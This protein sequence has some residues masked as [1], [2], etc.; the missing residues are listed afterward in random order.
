MSVVNFNPRDTNV[1]VTKQYLD[2]NLYTTSPAVASVILPIQLAQIVDQGHITSNTSSIAT[3]TSSIAT[4]TSSIATNTATIATNIVAI[5]RIGTGQTFDRFDINRIDSTLTGNQTLF[6]T[7]KVESYGSTLT[8]GGNTAT[9]VM[10]LGTST[11]MQTINIGNGASTGT[12]QI[13]LG[14]SGDTVV[15][16]GNTITNNTTNLAVTNKI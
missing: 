15:I 4:N 11:G 10:N 8:M 3:N 13:N 5:D 1:T 9:T 7:D 6:K 14:G 16:Q 2:T 12:T